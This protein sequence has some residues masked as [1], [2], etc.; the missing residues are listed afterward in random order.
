MNLVV[1]A[2]GLL[3]GEICRQLRQAGKPVRALTRPTADPLKV[4]QLKR[5]GATLVQGDV[6]DRASL[7]AAC[8]GAT[9]VITT[10]STTFTRLA[11]EGGGRGG[12]HG[13]S[14]PTR[15]VERRAILHVPWT[16]VAPK[17]LSCSTFSGSAVGR[18]SARTGLPACLNCRQI[19]P[20]KS[21]VAP[22]TRFICPP[23]NQRRGAGASHEA[24]HRPERRPVYLPT[25][26]HRTLVRRRRP[27]ADHSGRTALIGS[28]PHRLLQTV[29]KRPP[30]DV[31]TITRPMRDR[32]GIRTTWGVLTGLLSARSSV[33]A[34]G[35]QQRR[36]W[37]PKAKS[38]KLNKRCNAG[39]ARS[40]LQNRGLQ[41]RFL[42]GLLEDQLSH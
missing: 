33:S 16:R 38:L 22:T 39:V 5:L 42:P 25:I 34:G 26:P 15:G 32:K 37:W 36:R 4:E 9:A 12:D 17:R 30:S 23:R 21:P 3:G 27:S 1:G 13:G 29:P 19:S 40:G 18:V 14:A 35:V 24:S 20:P 8:R 41:V 2:T 28:A 11:R 31:A 10:A 7:D 6:K